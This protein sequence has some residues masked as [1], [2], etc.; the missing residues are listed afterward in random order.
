MICIEVG[1][2]FC[3]DLFLEKQDLYRLWKSCFDGWIMILELSI[4]E[5]NGGDNIKKWSKELLGFTKSIT[6]APQSPQ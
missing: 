2:T 4:F 1:T 5:K 3:S 6:F